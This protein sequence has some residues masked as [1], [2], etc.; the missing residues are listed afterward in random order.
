[1]VQITLSPMTQVTAY[2]YDEVFNVIQGGTYLES[3][4]YRTSPVNQPFNPT[5]EAFEF[6][7]WG[8]EGGRDGKLTNPIRV[9]AQI[10]LA[11]NP[12]DG[13]RRASAQT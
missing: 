3:F 11:S 5:T 1:M 8:R 9:N 13:W 10:E 12:D 2:R 6:V 4:E 7:F